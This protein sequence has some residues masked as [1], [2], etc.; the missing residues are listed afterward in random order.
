MKNAGGAHASTSVVGQVMQ[1]VTTELKALK[2]FNEP[3]GLYARMPLDLA[4]H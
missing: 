3:S 2:S 4:I 1:R